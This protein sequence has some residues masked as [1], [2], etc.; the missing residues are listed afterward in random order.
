[1]DRKDFLQLSA[2]SSLGI[3]FFSYTNSYSKIFPSESDISVD[4]F[5][6]FQDPENK[7]RPF[8]RWWWNGDKLRKEELLRE[9]DVL[10]AA[11]IGGVE[12][13]PIKFPERTNDLGIS[14]LEW[15]GDEWLEML[16]FTVNE[17][18]KRGLICDMIVGSGWPFGGEFLKKEEQIQLMAL[19]TRSL[20]A[21]TDY[22][23]PVTDILEE[24]SPKIY[25]PH[26]NS[27]KELH[28]V[29]LVP[30]NLNTTN[31]AIDIQPD[32]E[33][34]IRIQAQKTPKE[35]YYLVKITGYMAVINGAP[36]ANG[37]V[38]NHF[39]ESAI[40]NYFERMSK[41]LTE[42]LGNFGNYF[43][44]FFTDS[45]ELEGANWNE[46][47]PE[48]FK[49][50][51]GYDLEKYLPFLLFKIGHM[52]NPVQEDYGA[53]F[54]DEFQEKINR[55]RYDFET[56]KN[57][58]FRERFIEPFTNWCHLHGV[59]SRMQAYGRECHPLESSMHIDIPENE[60]WMGNSAG[61]VFSDENYREGRAYTM[62]N[63]FVSSGAR[64]AGK[65]LV[66]CEEITNTNRVFTTTLE[67]I[68]IAGDQSILSGVTHS[69]LHGFNYSPPEAPFPGWIRYGT[70][71]NERNTWW[72]YFRKWADY[73]ARLYAIFQNTELHS[74]I[75]ILHP[76]A[77]LWKIHGPMR[78]PFPEMAYPSYQHQVWEA[79]Q[80]C[81]NSA[82]YISEKIIQ[83]SQIQPKQIVYNERKYRVLMLLDVV[84]ML[85]ET[86][87]KIAE[88]QRQ[89]GKIIFVGQ[90]P[91]QTAMLQQ[92]EENRK[93]AEIFEAFPDDSKTGI[94]DR[95]QKD[96]I[97]WYQDIQKRFGIDP[98]IQ[99]S[100]PNK[101][102]SHIRYGSDAADYY[103]FVN[104]NQSESQETDL[105]FHS[106]RKVAEVW[107]PETGEKFRIK[108]AANGSYL[109]KLGPAESKLIVLRDQ[110]T[111][112]EFVS[113][114][115]ILTEMEKIN[116]PWKIKLHKV[117]GNLQN[118]EWP[119]LK[120]LKE[121]DDL[122]NFSGTLLYQT[123]FD[124]GAD[125]GQYF[126]DLGKVYGI[127]EVIL[128]GN[129]LGSVWYGKHQ[130]RLGKALRIGSNQLQV[131]ITTTLGNYM[132]SLKDNPVAQGW[133]SYQKLQ[134]S[135]MIG[136]VRI[137]TVS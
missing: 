48:V 19:G 33:G 103:F 42:K 34:M 1:M 109:L 84:S 14:S 137:Y 61:A 36:G 110:W 18:K 40:Q 43:R 63:K 25:S 86:A 97:S 16:E 9:L 89:G 10:Q 108:L 134:S 60:T 122:Q 100:K 129:K 51:F 38:L 112:E 130:Y 57:D 119:L 124:F 6:K 8:V 136:P 70:F 107:D 125:A 118:R 22:S 30:Q 13:N 21:N 87:R 81:G 78:D 45:I 37:P 65:K 96:F 92:A 66:S 123:N 17:A 58:L 72:P 74:D 55:V 28:M 104:Y 47:F 111:T 4:H 73:K 88:F 67:E 71:L 7:F 102:L 114:M 75:A 116:G 98:G 5:K 82:D 113:E 76:I 62:V 24:V 121:T 101:F 53:K 93:I 120:D 133:T 26:S 41:R 11:G 131:Q 128:N 52:G 44:A 20:Q 15:L 29:K 127:S 126:L 64:F 135:G 23:I 39:N 90:K 31:F 46:D 117:D 54:S 49:E 95:P 77:D 56:L 83:Q 68:K 105:I 2:L 79:I 12:I 59:Q 91:T 106:S 115:G 50:R 35:L 80:Q 27:F 99:I 3:S 94:V 69:I 132:K 85:P 32:A